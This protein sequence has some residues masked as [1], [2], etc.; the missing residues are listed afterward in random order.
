[1]DLPST[2]TDWAVLISLGFQHW[3]GDIDLDLYD[4]QGRILQFSP[5]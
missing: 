2:G 1:M 5:T 3:I 4:D